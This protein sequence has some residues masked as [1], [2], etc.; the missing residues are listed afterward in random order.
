MNVIASGVLQTTT[1]A[2]T[3]V[4][5][6]G[7]C[8]E[9]IVVCVRKKVLHIDLVVISVLVDMKLAMRPVQREWTCVDINICQGMGHC[10][11]ILL[12]PSINLVTVVA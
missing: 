6:A 9:E 12:T 8:A 3:G 10:S 1:G 4:Q 2:T 11:A 5:K 7:S